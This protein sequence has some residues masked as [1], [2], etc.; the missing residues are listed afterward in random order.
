VSTIE[1]GIP[2]LFVEGLHRSFAGVPVLKDLDLD[3]TWGNIQSI[4]GANGSGK[5][6]LVRILASLTR[7]DSGRIQIMGRELKSNSIALR[8]LV[9]FV[10][11]QPL[12]YGDL[13]GY[14]NLRFYGRMFQLQDL[15]SCIEQAAAQMGVLD[16]LNRQI[17]TLSHG[18]QKRLSLARA[19]LHKPPILLLDE[20][21]TGLDQEALGYLETMLEDGK[22]LPRTVLMTTHSL[23]RGLYLSDRVAILAKGRFVFEES[24]QN[25]DAQIL[26]DAI[27]THMGVSK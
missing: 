26:R 27:S 4:F 7:P 12:L 21:E 1:S 20:P 18:M 9:G 17:R 23:E 24:R 10:S 15:E 5:T 11:H 16:L 6:T 25:L 3:L 13:T 22:V 19:I 2:A 14:E 8:R